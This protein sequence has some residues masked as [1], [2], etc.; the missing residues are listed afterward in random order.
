[1]RLGLH[2]WPNRRINGHWLERMDIRGQPLI[3]VRFAPK[4][5]AVCPMRARCTRSETLPRTLAFRPKP[6]YLALQAARQRQTTDEFK[7]RYKTRA[8]VEG[9]FSQSVRL[10]HLRNARYLG[11]AKTR[12]QH[13]LT[14][15][16]LNLIRLA[17][18]L[19]EQSFA[20]TRRDPFTLLAPTA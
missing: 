17:A 11:L 14:A 15:A 5:C 12:L 18:W 3:S 2:S 10:N 20:Q 4:T 13:V 8:D 9:S 6:Q 7:D 16:A 19:D 1:M